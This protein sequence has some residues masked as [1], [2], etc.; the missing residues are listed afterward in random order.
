MTEEVAQALGTY[1]RRFREDKEWGV[2]EVARR[3]GLDPA[4]IVHL[5]SGKARH[6]RIDTLTSLARAFEVPLAEMLVHAGQAEP[7]GMPCIGTHLRLCY[8][9][10]PETVIREIEGYMGRVAEGIATTGSK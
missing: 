3:A 8:G 2:R 9:H 1:I 6:P 5:E 4:V 10:L 7:C